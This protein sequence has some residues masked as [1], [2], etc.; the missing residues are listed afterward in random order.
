MQLHVSKFDPARTFRK[1][2]SKRQGAPARSLEPQ[3]SVIM[4]SIQGMRAMFRTSLVPW[5]FWEE[6]LLQVRH[7][8]V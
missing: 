5:F 1:P 8:L 6:H 2:F 4:H 7:R 3:A